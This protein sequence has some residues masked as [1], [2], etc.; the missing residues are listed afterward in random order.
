MWYSPGKLLEE[1]KVSHIWCWGGLRAGFVLPMGGVR[2]KVSP[3]LF[4][5]HRSI[6]SCCRAKGVL[7]LMLAHWRAGSVPDMAGY[8]SEVSLSYFLSAGG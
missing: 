7:M 8:G 5:A 3:K 1:S 4:Q 2:A 6:V